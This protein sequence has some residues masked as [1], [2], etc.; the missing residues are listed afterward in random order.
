MLKFDWLFLGGGRFIGA[1]KPLNPLFPALAVKTHPAV[2]PDGLK[3]P[4]RNPW[5]RLSGV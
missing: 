1:A 2:I 5:R 4:I 3:R